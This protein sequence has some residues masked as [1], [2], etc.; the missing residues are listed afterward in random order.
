M[1]GCRAR[2]PLRLSWFIIQ[3]A[4]DIPF[5]DAGFEAATKT[6]WLLQIAAVML[7]LL[8]AGCSPAQARF[9]P[10]TVRA[11]SVTQGF[12]ASPGPEPLNTSLPSPTPYPPPPTAAAPA[13]AP[14]AASTTPPV[15]RQTRGQIESH[16]LP[17]DQLEL[18]M[19]VRIYTPPCYAANSDQRYPT[20]YLFHG[21]NF[22]VDQWDRVGVDEAADRLIRS[23]VIA[24]LLVVMPQETLFYRPSRTSF[25][26]V[27][28][29]ELLPWVEA[30]YRTLPDREH[31]AVGGLSRG[32]AWAVHFGL[33]YWQDFSRLGAHSAAAFLEDAKVLDTW[34]E[35]IPV[36]ELPRIYLDIGD[37][38]Y[39][40]ESNTWLLDILN[41]YNLPH[42]FYVFPGYHE[43]AYWSAHV[44]TYL[45]WYAAGW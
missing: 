21:A 15:C 12:T 37:R 7:A 17:S 20:L 9:Q 41:T 3:L 18:P 27:F 6:R 19:E 1:Q 39:L 36:G 10:A 14:L 44:E 35:E 32:G 42:E 24:P 38:D 11:D 40:Q 31:R 30:N 43:E 5:Q 25:D 2:H 26:E 22:D 13:R 4:M 29:E 23:G 34:L 28:L 8:A 16:Y 33:R 45:R